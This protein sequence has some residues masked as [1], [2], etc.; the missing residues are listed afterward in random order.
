MK[1][2]SLTAIVLCG[3]KQQRMGAYRRP[4]CLAA[5]KGGTVAGRVVEQL[6]AVASKVVV[7]TGYMAKEVSEAL[8]AEVKGA[9]VNFSN[10]GED[11]TIL[12]RIAQARYDAGAT[13]TLVCYGD[14]WADVDLPALWEFHSERRAHVTATVIRKEHECGIVDFQS[15]GYVE[16]WRERPPYFMNIGYMLWTQE[17]FRLLEK[18]KDLETLIGLHVKLGTVWAWVHR[19]RHVTVNRPSDLQQLAGETG[20]A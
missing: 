11:A 18:G 14:T 20:H 3:G 19:G 9:N 7:C 13:D 8:G 17:A 1:I 4:K 10:A 16:S 5:F 2:Q 12:D 6:G 15:D